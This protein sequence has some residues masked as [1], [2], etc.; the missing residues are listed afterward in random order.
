[1]TLIYLFTIISVII[2]IMFF[3]FL[4]SGEQV[5]EPGK[6]FKDYCNTCSC[7]K[8]GTNFACTLMFCDETI[9]N[10]DGTLKMNVTEASPEPGNLITFFSLN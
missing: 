9:W 7:S 8:D 3:F 5:C 4:V 10:K 1:M 6:A 2:V